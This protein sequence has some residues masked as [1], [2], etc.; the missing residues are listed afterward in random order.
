M[1]F[2]DLLIFDPSPSD[3]QLSEEN[4]NIKKEK[5]TRTRPRTPPDKVILKKNLYLVGVFS[6]CKLCQV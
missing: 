4:K 3:S 5:K 1:S 6:P 2:F